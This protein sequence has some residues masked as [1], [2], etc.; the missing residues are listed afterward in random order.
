MRVVLCLSGILL[1]TLWAPSWADDYSDAVNTSAVNRR[2][3][4]PPPP[5]LVPCPPLPPGG[6]IKSHCETPTLES[7][8]MKY[9]QTEG[10]AKRGLNFYYYAAEFL[11]R[12]RLS[13]IAVAHQANFSLNKQTL[14]AELGFPEFKKQM[15]REGQI[16]DVYAYRFDYQGNKDYLLIIYVTNDQV[17]R[18]GYTETNLEIDNT[19]RDY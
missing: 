2:T 8:K 18:T 4:K 12:H 17:Y 10:Y 5:P 13:R 11:D 19:W 1:L 7:L 9:L 14:F 16:L 15:H 6:K 3:P